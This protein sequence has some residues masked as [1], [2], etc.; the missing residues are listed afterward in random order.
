MNDWSNHNCSNQSKLLDMCGIHV[1]QQKKMWGIQVRQQ[2]HVQQESHV[3]YTC[4]ATKNMCRSKVM[5]MCGSLG[6]VR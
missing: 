5:I 4:A 2:K 6:K 3:R 1:R